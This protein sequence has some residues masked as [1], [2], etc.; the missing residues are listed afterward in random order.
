[1]ARTTIDDHIVSLGFADDKLNGKT[2]G[3]LS[4]GNFLNIH[5]AK[6]IEVCSI[7]YDCAPECDRNLNIRCLIFGRAQDFC[8]ADCNKNIFGFGGGAA[9]WQISGMMLSPKL[10]FGQIGWGPS[11]VLKIK[12]EIDFS[13]IGRK[14]SQTSELKINWDQDGLLGISEIGGGCEKFCGIDRNRQSEKRQQYIGNFEVIKKID[15]P[16]TKAVKR[17]IAISSVRLKLE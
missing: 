14:I 11:D 17:I 5:F 16:I 9:N 8:G 1:M 12:P 10:Q 15:E 6:N 3:V 2:L 7:F 13:F 4:S